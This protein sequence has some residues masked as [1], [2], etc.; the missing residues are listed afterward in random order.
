MGPNVK[1][2]KTTGSLTQ[3]EKIVTITVTVISDVI[4]AVFSWYTIKLILG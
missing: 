2:L 3:Q 1:D 4:I